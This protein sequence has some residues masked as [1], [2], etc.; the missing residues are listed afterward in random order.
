MLIQSVSLAGALMILAGFSMQQWG[1]WKA[2]DA[3]Y[4]W[5]NL[6]GAGVLTVVAWIESQWGFLLMESV[7][8]AVSAYSLV[9]RART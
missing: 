7:W 3:V 5:V 9:K 1:R 6:L 2:D 4:L 8:T